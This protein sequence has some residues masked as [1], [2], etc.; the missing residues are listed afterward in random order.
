MMEAS[1]TIGPPVS[2]GR[3]VDWSSELR[4]RAMVLAQENT[5]I[6]QKCTC[7]GVAVPGLISSDGNDRSV[8]VPPVPL[9]VKPMGKKEPGFP[10]SCHRSYM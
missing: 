6:Y 3:G 4:T 7:G 5:F 1:N 2:F 8:T 10:E 9:H